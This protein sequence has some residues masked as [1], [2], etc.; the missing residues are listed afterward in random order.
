[1][2]SASPASA[3]SRSASMASARAGL[4]RRRRR[5]RSRGGQKRFAFSAFTRQLCIA[6]SIRDPP[7]EFQFRTVTPLWRGVIFSVTPLWRG[8]NFIDPFLQSEVFAAIVHGPKIRYHLSPFVSTNDSRLNREPRR[9]GVRRCRAACGSGTSDSGETPAET[10]TALG[11]WMPSEASNDDPL[12]CR[13]VAEEV[14]VGVYTKRQ[15]NSMATLSDNK[16][17]GV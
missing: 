8:V 10:S 16:N 9:I 17:L 11:L 12:A 3:A 4:R 15:K 13:R 14:L 6:R 7:V 2:A 1:M 5:N